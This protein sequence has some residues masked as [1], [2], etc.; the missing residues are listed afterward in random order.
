MAQAQQ[1]GGDGLARQEGVLVQVKVGLQVAPALEEGVL[2]LGGCGVVCGVRVEGGQVEEVGWAWRASWGVRATTKATMERQTVSSHL[3]P[4]HDWLLCVAVS[5]VQGKRRRL[6]MEGSTSKL[7]HM[8]PAWGTAAGGQGSTTSSLQP[9]AT[10]ICKLARHPPL[11]VVSS[12]ASGW[13]SGPTRAHSSTFTTRGMSLSLRVGAHVC[14][15][16]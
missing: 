14:L 7:T 2:R 10:T 12:L 16:A 6:G 5:T 4:C 11:Y 3:G 1:V 9:A 15:C 13:D 8:D